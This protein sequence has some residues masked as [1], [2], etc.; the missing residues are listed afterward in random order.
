MEAPWRRFGPAFLLGAIVV[1]PLVFPA[2]LAWF[3]TVFASVVCCLL[4]VAGWR[5]GLR[6]LGY[7]LVGAAVVALFLRQLE[8]FLFFLS[9][10]PLGMVLARGV[11]RRES[12]VRTG[13]K[14]MAVL[15]LGWV[16]FWSLFAQLSQSDPYREMLEALDKGLG[17]VLAL[18]LQDSA[19]LSVEARQQVELVVEGL[20]AHLPRILPAMWL[21]M[22]TLAVWLNLILSNWLSARMGGGP[23]PWGRYRH[24]RLP[25]HLVWLPIAA[26]LLTFT[27]GSLQALALWTLFFAAMLYGFQG[28][29]ICLYFFERWRF[30]PPLQVLAVFLLIIQGY[31]L[32]L[33]ALL[34]LSEVWLNWRRQSGT[35]A[36]AG[37]A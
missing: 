29:A 23:Y 20:R 12:V 11:E 10:C 37:R 21:A 24:W 3:A 26:I 25:D 32:M 8:L 4:T 28:L 17:E 6:Q 33:L 36:D 31:G 15:V 35:P 18:Y 19:E 22:A 2:L 14:G 27:G 13:A 7:G 16:L 30:P 5:P 34:G 9:Y 1:V